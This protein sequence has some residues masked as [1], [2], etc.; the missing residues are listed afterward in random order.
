MSSQKENALNALRV[1]LRDKDVGL[2]DEIL[3]EVLDRAQNPVE[4]GGM[5]DGSVGTELYDRIRKARNHLRGFLYVAQT[6]MQ[7][8]AHED[9]RPAL[10]GYGAPVE[11]VPLLNPGGS[12]L[13]GRQKLPM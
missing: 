12:S 11:Q 2:I 4:A 13:P 8:E 6:I 7:Q 9:Y 5:S 3:N 1:L 10:E